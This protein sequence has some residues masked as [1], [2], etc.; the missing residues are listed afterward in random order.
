MGTPLSRMPSDGN[1]GNDRDNSMGALTGRLADS[2]RREFPWTF[3]RPITKAGRARVHERP[4]AIRDAARHTVIQLSR[5]TIPLLACV[6]L[7]GCS[8]VMAICIIN[9]S[10]VSLRVVNINGAR[11]GPLRLAPQS[12]VIVGQMYRPSGD[13]PIRISTEG[14]HR[15]VKVNPQ[16][17]NDGLDRDI[18]LIEVRSK[19]IMSS[20]TAE[21]KN[22]RRGTVPREAK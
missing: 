17:S 13:Y 14:T 10:D 19:D 15:D 9:Y 21:G 4:R 3:S 20:V 6:W 8:R 12:T 18:L 11:K 2:W 22:A 5:C 16:V 7:T 1:A